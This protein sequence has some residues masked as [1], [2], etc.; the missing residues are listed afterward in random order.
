MDLRPGDYTV[1]FTLAGFKTFKRDG[2]E[3]PANF[4]ATVNADM[5]VGSLEETIT[6][7]GEAP[8]V[9]VQRTQ[10]QAAVPARDAAV[11]A[12]HGP[13][14]RAWPASSPAPRW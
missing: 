4:T 6:V 3:L 1:T 8:I 14:H 11:A 9:D 2:M 13:D 12:G 5:S 10:Q 7:S